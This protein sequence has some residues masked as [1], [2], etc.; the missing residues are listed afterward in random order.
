MRNKSNRLEELF[1]KI[2]QARSLAEQASV[3]PGE[4]DR[5]LP[6]PATAAVVKTSPTPATAAAT[7]PPDTPSHTVFAVHSPRQPPPDDERNPP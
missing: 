5:K 3:M 7:L 6:T 1:L 2:T 4:E